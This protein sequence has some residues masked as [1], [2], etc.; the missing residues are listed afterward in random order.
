MNTLLDLISFALKGVVVVVAVLLVTGIV[1]ALLRRTRRD[2]ARLTVHKLNDRFRDLADGLRS[3][4]LQPKA[5]KRH[6]AVTKRAAKHPKEAE[7]RIFVLDF[8]GDMAASAVIS[9]R[10]EISAILGVCR[11][12]DEVVVRLESSGGIVQAYGLAASQLARLKGRDL[13]LVVCVDKIAAS[14]GYMMACLADELIAAP[15]AVIGSIG[16]VAP[17]PNINK[18]LLEH[19]VEYDEMTAGEFKRTVSVLGKISPEGRAKFQT[20][21]EETHGLFKDFVREHRPG[22]D[23]DA[24]ATGEYWF[25]K[26][27]LEK[28]LVDRLLTSDDYLLAQCAKADLF[29]VSYKPREPWRRRLVEAVGESATRLVHKGWSEMRELLPM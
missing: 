21:L 8:R 18:L 28:K 15:F 25:G 27:A 1:V 26:R 20:Q 7:H 13:K 29:L 19:G 23:I 12:G 5:W 17:V 14:G 9:L 6:L 3:V 4:V 16:V 22:L 2:E 10:E 11:A 24:V